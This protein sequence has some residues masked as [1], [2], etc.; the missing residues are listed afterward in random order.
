ME[1]ALERVRGRFRGFDKKK[2]RIVLF[3]LRG[4]ESVLLRGFGVGGGK[5]RQFLH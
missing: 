3:V 1:L 5:H 4:S 2:R